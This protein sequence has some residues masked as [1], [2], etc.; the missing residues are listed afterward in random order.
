MHILIDTEFIPAGDI[1]P[2]DDQHLHYGDGALE[3]VLELSPGEHTLYLQFADGAH[4]ALEGDQYRD[5]I[6]VFVEEDAARPVG[7]LL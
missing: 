4:T 2:A 5:T 7:R 1:I 6:V 3:A